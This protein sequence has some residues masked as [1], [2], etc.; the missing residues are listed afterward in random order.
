MTPEDRE[1]LKSAEWITASGTQGDCL[2]AAKL[3]TGSIA[4]RE[5]E[6]PDVDPIITS[7]S[8]WDALKRG[9]ENGVFPF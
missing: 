6:T 1:A 3:S 4:L 8:N 7:Q 2:Y 5:S 9:I